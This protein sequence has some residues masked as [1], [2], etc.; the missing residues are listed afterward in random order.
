MLVDEDMEG[1]FHQLSEFEGYPTPM[2]ATKGYG[3]P[4]FVS[5]VTAM[6]TEKPLETSTPRLVKPE[7]TMDSMDTSVSPRVQKR[8]ISPPPLE[9]NRLSKKVASITSVTALQ[10]TSPP[11]D[12]PKSSQILVT[13]KQESISPRIKDSFLHGI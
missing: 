10:Q 2:T 11:E 5:R 3:G 1:Y 7:S 4:S 6:K 12:V 13:V 9:S 8:M